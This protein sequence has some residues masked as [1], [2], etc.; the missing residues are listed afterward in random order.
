MLLQELNI[1]K[2]NQMMKYG[3][4][5]LIMKTKY[6]LIS[7]FVSFIL[8]GCL[9]EKEPEQPKEDPHALKPAI[10]WRDNQE[11]KKKYWHEFCRNVME[12]RPSNCRVIRSLN[13]GN[14][15][16]AQETYNEILKEN[17]AAENARS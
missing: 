5:K 11:L 4:R 1:Q 6:I 9:E 12:G 8:S 7:L 10:F 2:I 16:E 14:L 13:M 17:N 15:E 3:N